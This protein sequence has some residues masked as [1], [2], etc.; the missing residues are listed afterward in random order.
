MITNKSTKRKA[1]QMCSRGFVS[2]VVIGFADHKK[3]KIKQ[4]LCINIMTL[5]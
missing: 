3:Y 2:V 4:Y 1:T 5:T